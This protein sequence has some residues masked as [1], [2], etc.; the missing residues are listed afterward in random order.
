MEIP[1]GL[2]LEYKTNYGLAL[3]DLDITN[4]VNNPIATGK[5]SVF[6]LGLQEQFRDLL[7][8]NPSSFGED[9]PDSLERI[10]SDIP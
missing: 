9:L 10:G 4:F 2:S 8:T 1:D 3:R 7:T 6:G 5:C